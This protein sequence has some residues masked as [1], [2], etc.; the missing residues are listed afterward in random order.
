LKTKLLSKL[1]QVFQYDTRV[2]ERNRSR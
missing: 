1:K 2:Q